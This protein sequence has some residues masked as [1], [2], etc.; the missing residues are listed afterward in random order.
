MPNVCIDAMGCG[1][2][3]AG[4]AEAGTPYVAPKEFGEF[5]PTYDIDALANVIANVSRKDEARI[6]ACHDYA[7]GR[8]APEVVMSKL[9]NIYKSL[10]QK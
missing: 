6:K 2:P 7:V 1:T 8:Y 9:D 5:T 10:I 4:F 3:L